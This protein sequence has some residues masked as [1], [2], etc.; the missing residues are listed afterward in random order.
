MWSALLPL[1]TLGSSFGIDFPTVRAGH[2]SP[3]RIIDGVPIS[4]PISG[5]NYEMEV[6]SDAWQCDVRSWTRAPDLIPGTEMPGET[7]LAMNGT[8]CKDIVKWELGLRYQ[9][10][11]VIKMRYVSRLT[12][13]PLFWAG[14]GGK[15][16]WK[17][18]D[19]RQKSRCGIPRKARHEA[20]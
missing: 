18:S 10:R 13:Q 11:A 12:Q 14:F 1:L 6:A 4:F 19:T 7:R 16:G 17:G 3:K 15:Q 20:L 8:D 9:E 5:A 2:G